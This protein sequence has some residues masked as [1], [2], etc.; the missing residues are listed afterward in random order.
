MNPQ[1]SDASFR[2]DADS[3]SDGG[4]V[5]TKI[6]MMEPATALQQ[7]A[8]PTNE[9]EP[10]E[11]QQYEQQERSSLGGSVGIIE[12]STGDSRHS[13]QDLD[14][15][16]EESTA[17]EEEEIVSTPGMQ[18]GS[19]REED[20]KISDSNS[21][22]E[23]SSERSAQ[24]SSA[25]TEET[26]L[27]YNNDKKIQREVDSRD[28][29]AVERKSGL[30]KSKVDFVNDDEDEICCN[31]CG[32]GSSYVPD[33]MI[34]CQYCRGVNYCSVECLQWDWESGGH[35]K[36]CVPLPAE[37]QVP[38]DSTSSSS[39]MLSAQDL[40]SL[41]LDA[42]T[43][44]SASAKF[45]I[46][47][48]ALQGSNSIINS[49]GPAAGMMLTLITS[50]TDNQ[51][52][53]VA[54]FYNDNNQSATLSDD[55]TGTASSYSS[56]VELALPN[57]N[58]V[59]NNISRRANRQATAPRITSNITDD[60]N[61]ST[62][63]NSWGSNLTGSNHTSGTNNSAR[64]RSKRK[65]K[66]LPPPSSPSIMP[67]TYSSGSSNKVSKSQDDDDSENDDDSYDHSDDDSGDDSGDDENS[68]EDF[69]SQS[70]MQLTPSK[71]EEQKFLMQVIQYNGPQRPNPTGLSERPTY[72]QEEDDSF[73]I[74][75]PPPDDETVLHSII[76]EETSIS[77]EPD[78][79]G[80][81]RSRDPFD[82]SQHQHRITM[83]NAATAQHQRI[84]GRTDEERSESSDDDDEIVGIVECSV[85]AD[86]DNTGSSPVDEVLDIKYEHDHNRGEAM[87]VK[88]D[89][90]KLQHRYR[91]GPPSLIPPPGIYEPAPLPSWQRKQASTALSSVP[92]VTNDSVSAS[93]LPLS[94]N[95]LARISSLSVPSN[96]PI[97]M[98]KNKS[99]NRESP[100]LMSSLQR[101]HSQ[102]R[103]KSHPQQTDQKRPALQSFFAEAGT[104]KTKVSSEDNYSIESNNLQSLLGSI[105]DDQGDTTDT[106]SPRSKKQK[107]VEGAS[108]SQKRVEGQ[109]DPVKANPNLQELD[110]STTSSEN[111]DDDHHNSVEKEPSVQSS[112]TSN[113][114]SFAAES[115]HIGKLRDDSIMEAISESADLSA[116][117]SFAGDGSCRRPHVYH[118]DDSGEEF[119]FARESSWS[120]D[121][122]KKLFRGS[123]HI[124]S[125]KRQLS[126]KSDDEDEAGDEEREYG[127]VTLQANIPAKDSNR[128]WPMVPVAA[129]GNT[130]DGD[131]S[132]RL[133]PD[134]NNPSNVTGNA[135]RGIGLGG[136]LQYVK[137]KGAI[138][139]GNNSGGTSYSETSISVKSN[140]QS[141]RDFRDAYEKGDSSSLMSF[142]QVYHSDASALTG[143][144]SGESLHSV[145]PSSASKAGGH[146]PTEN[147]SFRSGFSGL[148]SG[149]SGHKLSSHNTG[150]QHGANS[151]IA[152]ETFGSVGSGRKSTTSRQSSGGESW[153]AK[154]VSDR[155]IVS[156]R[157]SGDTT[158]SFRSRSETLKISINKALRDYEILYGE[159][160]AQQAFQKLAQAVLT[161]DNEDSKSSLLV[162]NVDKEQTPQLAKAPE[163]LET[164]G[165]DNSSVRSGLSAS[166]EAN[167]GGGTSTSLI[168]DTTSTVPL[169][170]ESEG[171]RSSQSRVSQPL[172]F[173]PYYNQVTSAS[174][175]A[176]PSDLS[177]F[178]TVTAKETNSSSSETS[179]K[180]SNTESLHPG[181]ASAPVGRAT[182][183]ETARY[184]ASISS[185]ALPMDLSDH[186]TSDRSLNGSRHTQNSAK[187]SRRPRWVQ[188][189]EKG[190]TT[191]K[192]PEQASDNRSK[193]FM[194]DKSVH[195]DDMSPPLKPVQQQ[196]LQHDK[197]R[198]IVVHR[199][200]SAIV[201]PI[202]DEDDTDSPPS[203]PGSEQAPNVDVPEL[204]KAKRLK[205]AP[206][207]QKQPELRLA[208]MKT[209]SSKQSLGKSA[210][211]L[212][213]WGSSKT[214]RDATGPA[215]GPNST[216]P[217]VSITASLIYREEGPR[218]LRYRSILAKSAIAL[219]SATL[220]RV[221]ARSIDCTPGFVHVSSGDSRSSDFSPQIRPSSASFD[222]FCESHEDSYESS[223]HV[224]QS[225]DKQSSRQ[226]SRE[227]NSEQMNGTMA[228]KSLTT[229]S[230][231]GEDSPSRYSTYR[232]FLAQKVVTPDRHSRDS[233][234]DGEVGPEDPSSP[235][236]DQWATFYTPD[237]AR[238]KI[239]NAVTPDSQRYL[240]YRSSLARRVFVLYHAAVG[241]EDKTSSEQVDQG[242]IADST[243]E[244]SPTQGKAGQGAVPQDDAEAQSRQP[245]HDTAKDSFSP[246]TP[247][248]LKRDSWLGL[249][250]SPLKDGID[251]ALPLEEAKPR[252]EEER[253]VIASSAAASIFSARL[254][255]QEVAL[256]SH[257]IEAASRRP[258]GI[259]IVSS[260][261]RVSN[262]LD[263]TKP[264][265]AGVSK[266]SNVSQRILARELALE[267]GES[268][269][270]Y[271]RKPPSGLGTS[272][273]AHLANSP[274][275]SDR[276]LSRKLEL[277]LDGTSD[278][279][280]RKPP[281]NQSS[282][283]SPLQIQ[284]G[285]LASLAKSSNLSHRL[286]AQEFALELGDNNSADA[287]K[288]PIS[289]GLYYDKFPTVRDKPHLDLESGIRP[290]QRLEPLLA[291]DAEKNS[292]LRSCNK[293][294]LWRWLVAII[295]LIGVAVAISLGVLFGRGS[296]S[297]SPL[298]TSFNPNSPTVR[299]TSSPT[300]S[301]APSL[302][303]APPQSFPDQ[304]L[305]L[306]LSNAS[307]DSG[308]GLQT[309]NSPQNKAYFWL[310]G[311][312]M[313][314]LS[315]SRK[316]QRYALATLYYSTNG[317]NWT[318]KGGWLTEKNECVWYFRTSAC[319]GEVVK[320]LDLS[321][322]G[323]GGRIPKEI[324][325]L[326]EVTSIDFSGGSG[327]K[328]SGP[329][330]TELGLLT[331]MES[332]NVGGNEISGKIPAGL[333]WPKAT[334]L[335]VQRNKLTGGLPDDIQLMISLKA[336]I[337]AN[338]RISGRLPSMIGNLKNLETVD[339]NENN[340]TGALPDSIGNLVLLKN[341]DF[342]Q[343]Q[344]SWLTSAIG[345]L[346]NLVNFNM[347][348]NKLKG[349][350]FDGWGSLRMLATLNLQGNE[351]D[352]SIPAS[353][354]S[355]PNIQ[356]LD[357]S[358]NFFNGTIPNEIGNLTTVVTV[359]LNS[360][361]LSG[362]IPSALSGLSNIS[363]LRLDDNNLQGQVPASLCATLGANTIYVP[364]FYSDCNPFG[365][366]GE[367]QCPL[368]FCC[369]HCCADGAGC[370]CVFPANL[371]FLC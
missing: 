12:E 200:G 134:S 196:L 240:Q 138:A 209:K 334:V 19:M 87:P 59:S 30:G 254:L 147:D 281:K 235:S 48:Y 63:S 337:L 236:S 307:S 62:L 122:G 129:N 174:S 167:D 183:G 29:F 365:G 285:T 234:V 2:H 286:I 222:D 364:K 32:F 369:T 301:L 99:N 181:I 103:Q 313:T 120:Q 164:L 269:I 367:I 345:S 41:N 4:G 123:G 352:G 265:L 85:H 115:G 194:N 98:T 118:D 304:S 124:S 264:T 9:L 46:D 104:T 244:R 133:V 349:P 283:N 54:E 221:D 224:A 91:N 42:D 68:T 356:S 80:S 179:D 220:T 10:L 268:S 208:K 299:P 318:V 11:Q 193:T 180:K 39:M 359:Y 88:H 69:P 71:L 142:R 272:V 211:K 55:P 102:S 229:N 247:Y 295:L 319:V 338:N 70:A 363:I 110:S 119:R 231:C 346:S 162:P 23:L 189:A 204:K 258:P 161:T 86:D 132:S 241:D 225:G 262:S 159:E 215:T 140:A 144:G 370:R 112:E 199:N 297:Q 27:S 158:R 75:D 326:R 165:K 38:A 168:N 216:E 218:Y 257:E 20:Q 310:V 72:Y 73:D 47:M 141:Y 201:M 288:P 344:F 150:K 155:S 6:M 166:E 255:A 343:N 289:R 171:D 113:Q 293:H 340:F 109:I 163:E 347:Q 61:D 287:R 259:T 316:I 37:A 371:N 336:L 36:T 89:T 321:L 351:I 56:F 184:H 212:A 66:L 157:S 311:T 97:D 203:S 230:F 126:G 250:L 188:E 106:D 341:L 94:Q 153:D 227:E 314:G 74:L 22:S 276:L 226:E 354:G 296:G 249:D 332:F 137:T 16:V 146:S 15:E 322:N 342:S 7:E 197:S 28:S 323:M 251:T 324:G 228:V 152:D 271:G 325:L 40:A 275:V 187:G 305:V 78:R 191:L 8:A 237:R 50:K 357:L 362:Q 151:S 176:F 217:T 260:T 24:T 96:M 368:G 206:Q 267:M 53:T 116:T 127:T 358:H 84:L 331:A 83:A 131:K 245:D 223:P 292:L 135:R 214:P 21:S 282:N 329:L 233:G 67:V 361:R 219:T 14:N 273:P 114:E 95:T 33:G 128:K 35:C 149:G 121:K 198:S 182:L 170:P 253:G 13:H 169:S 366:T 239:T 207:Q 327:I 105:E 44:G 77:D 242:N 172:H 317:E 156:R 17:E 136:G 210:L 125:S 252:L 303:P 335:D 248:K 130:K 355:L 232:Y 205:K 266:S 160:A 277:K 117:G 309:R 49:P 348:G 328:L 302:A 148:G 154:K 82:G 202:L 192:R 26:P 256:E 238:K 190:K 185:W 5:G 284:G 79:E 298:T 280:P 145:N 52:N 278:P 339:V 34:T 300:R 1:E 246:M 173:P 60:S 306:L 353:M 333:N 290:D 92:R 107:Y 90:I 360:N 270:A 178:S 139:K 51:N 57:Q 186:R 177:T 111:E 308:V 330:P 93:L 294:R 45:S 213:T 261:S 279:E 350:L 312:N 243:L 25:R 31:A 58:A 175:W 18:G 195:D 76:E 43:M 315:N 64:R 81:W 100:A 263:A 320:T 65:R 291:P 101:Q 143:L 274:N 3:V 108:Q